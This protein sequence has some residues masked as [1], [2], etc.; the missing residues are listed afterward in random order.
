MQAVRKTQ[1]F[2]KARHG[3]TGDWT[4]FGTGQRRV[5]ER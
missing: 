5:K 4:G 2:L 3:K 1:E